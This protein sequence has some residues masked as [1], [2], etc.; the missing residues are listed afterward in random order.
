[1]TAFQGNTLMHIEVIAAVPDQQP[2]LAN[3]LELYAHDF[4]EFS[5]LELGVDGRFGYKHLPLYWEEPDR[6]PFLVKI[7]DRL[8]GF[9]LVKRGSEVSGKEDVWDMAEFFVMRRYRKRG[10]GTE[11]AHEVWRRFPGV[12]E[13]R[14]MQSNHPAA[15]FWRRSITKFIGKAI[16][17][18]CIEKDGASWHLFT[19]DTKRAA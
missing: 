9:V 19:F 1:M 4:S 17:S 8:A 14:V 3:L 18:V 2:I 6:H 15:E 10:I 11:V 16:R 5:D 7:D 13:V 12:W